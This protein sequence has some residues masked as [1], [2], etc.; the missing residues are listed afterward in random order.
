MSPATVFT[1]S[2][3][4][5]AFRALEGHNFADFFMTHGAATGGTSPAL[6]VSG[7]SSQARTLRGRPEMNRIAMVLFGGGII[8]GLGLVAIPTSADPLHI[9]CTSSTVCTGASVTLA[10]SNTTPTFDIISMDTGGLRG[11][12]FLGVLVP[13]VLGPDAT[14]SFTVTGGTF[15]QS[16]AFTSGALG[17][18]G[19]LNEPFFSDYTLSSLASASAQAGVTASSFTAYEFNLGAYD[20][21]GGGAAGIS[22]LSAGSLPTGTVLV[23]WVE[24]GAGSGVQTPLSESLTVVPEPG[25]LALLGSGLVG[26]AALLRKRLVHPIRDDVV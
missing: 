10:T 11:T 1:L 12:G 6:P 7:E 4:A 18:V 25:T 15:Q 14:A 2:G 9:A 21:P 23:A 26:L 24:T 13:S 19:N 17:D 3:I 16:I 8:M 20:S 22:G 5:L